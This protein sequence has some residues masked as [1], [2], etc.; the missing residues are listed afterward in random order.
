MQFAERLRVRPG[1]HRS[2]LL[3]R[4][5]AVLAVL[6]VVVVVVVVR[7]PADNG[8]AQA[9]RR[10]TAP[11]TPPTATA[12]L[13][14][15]EY[16]VAPGGDDG[17]SGAVQQPWGTLQHALE[18]LR[19]GDRLIVGGGEYHEN[20]DVKANAGRVDAPVQVIAA[21]G[22]RP[23]VVGLLWLSAASY[24][25]IRGINVTW[26]DHNSADQ[27]MV[28]L[29]DGTGWLFGDAE[30]WGAKSYAALLV[31]GHPKHF[32]LTG[33]YVHDTYPANDTNQD[34]LIYLNCG[35]GGGVVERSVLARSANGRALKIG[36][37]D[38]GNGKVANIVVRY[39]TMVD[40]RGPSNVQL[41]YDTSNVVIEHS[42]MAGAHEG[43][44]NVTVFQLNGSGSV[45]RDSLGWD[46]TGLLDDVPGLRDGGGNVSLDPQLTG[47]RGAQPYTPTNPKAQAYGRWA[48]EG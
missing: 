37:A 43:R 5:A 11:V 15:H 28:K 20:V 4:L 14:G 10:P 36:S 41:A 22:A 30:L 16:A 9:D 27:H 6:V 40:N 39:V 24:W 38:A 29:T 34:H 46:S 42:L 35:T 23:L 26:D 2:A 1:G 7:G 45:V 25:D 17:A 31:D 33:L 48:A 47:A 13:R 19:A 44:N 12:P 3:G 18:Q 8:G 21:A 32:T